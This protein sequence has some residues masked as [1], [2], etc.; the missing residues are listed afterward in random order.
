MSVTHYS[1]VGIHYARYARTHTY[2][3]THI[4]VI[5]YIEYVHMYV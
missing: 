2:L 5:L 3:C 1:D 4:C